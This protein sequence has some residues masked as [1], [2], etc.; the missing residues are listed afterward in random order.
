VE[1]EEEEVAKWKTTILKKRLNQSK[2]KHPRFSAYGISNV[3]IMWDRRAT[4]QN[5][6]RYQL[7]AKLR[8]FDVLIHKNVLLTTQ[9]V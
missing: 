2:R 7:L 8:W 9:A 1:E 3:R 4:V 5:G 6:I